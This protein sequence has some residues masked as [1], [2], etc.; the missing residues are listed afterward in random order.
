MRAV[1]IGNG[2]IHNYE[3]IKTKLRKDDFIICADGGL[4]HTSPLGVSPDIAIGDLIHHQR[5]KLSK[6]MNILSIK[7]LQT[8][9]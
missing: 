8:A 1:I 2:D 6:R 3:Y 9:N 5:M 4:R 7:I